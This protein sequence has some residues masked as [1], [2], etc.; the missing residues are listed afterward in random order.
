MKF[1]L[2]NDIRGHQEVYCSDKQY[3]KLSKHPFA[4]KQHFSVW[5]NA[6]CD[7]L[8][9]NSSHGYLNSNILHTIL[10]KLSYLNIT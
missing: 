7:H 4:C 3:Q 9:W 8:T 6:V 2:I 1:Q 5:Q 10:I